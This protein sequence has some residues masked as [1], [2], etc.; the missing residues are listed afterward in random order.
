MKEFILVGFFLFIQVLVADE[1][2]PEYKTWTSKAGTKIKA[3]LI[4]AKH[5]EVKLKTKTGKIISLHPHKLSEEDQKFVFTKFP[6]TEIA[7]SIIGKRI[8]IDDQGSTVT[9]VF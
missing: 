2:E 6:L 1:V 7:K 3:S 8:I 5:Y 4:S 9:V